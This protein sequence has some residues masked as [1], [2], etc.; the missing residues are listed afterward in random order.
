MQGP[1]I[2]ALN[3]ALGETV[4]PMRELAEDNR[5]ARLL[6]RAVTFATGARWHI[7]RPTPIDELAWS[8]V[9]VG[10]RHD[11]GQALSVVAKELGT[12]KL[13]Q[14]SLPPVLVL[15]SDSSPTDDFEAGLTDLMAQPWGKHAV[16]L[17]VAI[18]DEA[19][20][21]VLQRFIGKREIRPL[22]ARNFC[23][24]LNY[25]RWTDVDVSGQTDS[26]KRDQADTRSSDNEHKGLAEPDD[27]F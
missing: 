2:E 18:G 5:H 1:K 20:L 7:E 14:V 27:V 22:Q 17:A 6:V 25:V 8:A 26:P 9:E 11:M 16:R 19:D 24:V 3:C 4:K 12:A 15:L 21:N 13:G 10:G 23:D